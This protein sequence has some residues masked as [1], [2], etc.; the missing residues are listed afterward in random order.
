MAARR[1]DTAGPEQQHPEVLHDGNLGVGERNEDRGLQMLA[2]T[3]TK[4]FVAS[5]HRS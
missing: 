1:R 5:M 3:W 2:G 4:P